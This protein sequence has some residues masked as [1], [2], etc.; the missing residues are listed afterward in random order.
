MA[1][2]TIGAVSGGRWVRVR[3]VLL[4]EFREML[5][6]TV[7]FFVGFNLILLSKR[8]LLA[9]YLIQFSG[10]VLATTS[11]LVVGK[12]VL[13]AD[14]MPFL[15]RFDRAPLVQ[16]ILF[17]TIV[18][19][20]LVFV[21]RL[22]EALVHY[23]IQ[24]GGVGDGGFLND[25]LGSFSW[26][27][28]IAVQMWIFVLFLVYVTASELNDLVGDGELFKIF[29]TRRS[30]ELKSTRRARIRLLV[31]LSR[32]TDTHSLDVLSDPKTPPHGELVAILQNLARAG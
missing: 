22:L 18:Y 7:F 25:L 11:A 13:V 9:D 12:T 30:S 26:D 32:L 2:R 5:P 17:K 4:H 27:H 6:P 28:F 23:L 31:Q 24:G 3:S 15:R 1:T 29:F 16:P 19:T 8:L 14:M 21:V 10:F 20:F